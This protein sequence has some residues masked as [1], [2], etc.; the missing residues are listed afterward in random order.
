MPRGA[1]IT[2]GL[3][4]HPLY[5]KWKCMKW[6]C[7]NPK[8]TFFKDYGARGIQVCEQWL[9]DP[10]AF[11]EW[12]LTNGWQ[13]GLQI[14]RINNDGNY[15]PSNCRFVPNRTNS[16]NRRCSVN[17][18]LPLGVFRSGNKYKSSVWVNGK[19][20][21]LGTFDTQ[22]EAAQAYQKALDRHQS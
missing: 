12:S 22:E 11:V 14:D 19:T 5:N 21:Y 15:E 2:H 4:K 16:Q 1:K 10:K 9:N 3:T 20:K 8:H 7:C 6:R 18:D 13:K 17:R